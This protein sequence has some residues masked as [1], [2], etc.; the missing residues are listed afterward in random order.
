MAF[1]FMLAK[2]TIGDLLEDGVLSLTNDAIQELVQKSFA[3]L[4][5][6][7]PWQFLQKFLVDYCDHLSNN[8]S[9]D[10]TAQL[11]EFFAGQGSFTAF[12]Q[13]TDN[14]DAAIEAAKEIESYILAQIPQYLRE[15]NRYA[16]AL[17]SSLARISNALFDAQTLQ[18]D[19]T[20][21][22]NVCKEKLDSDMKTQLGNIE[23]AADE[24]NFIYPLKSVAT[25][26]MRTASAYCDDLL[27]Y[28]PGFVGQAETLVNEAV[29]VA[30]NS[31]GEAAAAQS[32]VTSINNQ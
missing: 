6:K 8:L 12:A 25:I 5:E 17:Q 21:A 22:V 20:A 4:L 28:I 24:N 3:E 32:R 9:N 16:D 27:L 19:L 7:H 13:Q 29:T 15:Y 1:N 10:I 26:I 2:D 23:T 31:A 14:S 30:Q 11:G 18:A